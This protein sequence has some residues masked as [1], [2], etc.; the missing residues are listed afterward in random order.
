MF[1]YKTVL[2]LLW[3]CYWSCFYNSIQI[4]KTVFSF[5]TLKGLII[6]Y[7]STLLKG[8]LFFLILFLSLFSFSFLAVKN[9]LFFTRP[10]F[11]SILFLL[12]F[13]LLFI[14]SPYLS[15]LSSPGALLLLL[16]LLLFCFL[17]FIICSYFPF[18]IFSSPFSFLSLLFLLR[19]GPFRCI[20]L[21]LS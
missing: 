17:L 8:L 18:F 1:Y 4:D 12:F 2:C 9:Y 13:F 20:F 19:I 14:H 7:A 5:T 21:Y 3:S 16:L 6:G 11:Y 15:S 10:P